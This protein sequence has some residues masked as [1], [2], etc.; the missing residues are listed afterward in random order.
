MFDWF[1]NTLLVSLNFTGKKIIENF[2]FS[3]FLIC[4]FNLKCLLGFLKTQ[5]TE[6]EEF[7]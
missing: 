1:L 3:N 7:L 6:G 4:N 5:K 2:K